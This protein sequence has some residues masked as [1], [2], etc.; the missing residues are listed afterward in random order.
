M[1]TA[2]SSVYI[3]CTYRNIIRASNFACALSRSPTMLCIQLYTWIYISTLVRGI[4][5]GDTFVMDLR[6][7]TFSFSLWYLNFRLPAAAKTD[8]T[9]R[10][11]TGQLWRRGSGGR[12]RERERGGVGGGRGRGRGRG[13]DAI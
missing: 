2:N 9:A 12:E 5:G 3:R 8:L 10:M 1:S 13:R 11:L 6:K 4:V 7:R